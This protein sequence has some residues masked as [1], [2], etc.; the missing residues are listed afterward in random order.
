M[1]APSGSG[2]RVTDL[3]PAGRK[4]G[5]AA[6]GSIREPRGGMQGLGCPKRSVRTDNLLPPRG[7]DV[8][9]AG[10][11][12]AVYKGGREPPAMGTLGGSGEEEAVGGGARRWKSK[13][14]AEEGDHE[15]ES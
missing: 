15:I 4:K 10:S 11:Q 5:P 7:A 2:I 9:T 1:D 3:R 12:R 13:Q 8:S 14:G 6:W